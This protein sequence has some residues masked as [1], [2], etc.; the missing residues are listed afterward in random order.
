MYTFCRSFVLLLVRICT[1]CYPL[2][3]FSYISREEKILLL[4]PNYPIR[5][6]FFRKFLVKLS[7]LELQLWT[8][9]IQLATNLPN[10]FGQLIVDCW[11]KSQYTW[12]RKR[13]YFDSLPQ[14]SWGCYCQHIGGLVIAIFF[15]KTRRYMA[16]ALILAYSLCGYDPRVLLMENDKSK[17]QSTHR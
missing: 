5:E 15:F 10:E 12:N 1:I 6:S 3:R 14:R 4:P 11:Y 7:K 16:H 9:P 8:F 17:F 2:S 13:H